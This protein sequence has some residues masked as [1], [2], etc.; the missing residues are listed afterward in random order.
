MSPRHIPARPPP[1][2]PPVSVL[3]H[4]N[5]RR[6]V[7]GSSGLNPEVLHRGEHEQGTLEDASLGV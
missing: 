1:P 2:P 6:G 7:M 4:V 3:Y 5:E